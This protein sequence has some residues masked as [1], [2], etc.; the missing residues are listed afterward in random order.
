VLWTSRCGASSALDFGVVAHFHF[1]YIILIYRRKLL[2]YKSRRKFFFYFKY[3]FSSFYLT[4]LIYYLV[5]I[6]QKTL[7]CAVHCIR[8]TERALNKIY[9]RNKKN[10][11]FFFVKWNFCSY[12]YLFRVPIRNQHIVILL[13][14][15]PG[16]KC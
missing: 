15:C 1:T 13:L 9:I 16:Y 8:H 5:Y 6:K 4:R 7:Q 12:Y 2:N 11:K 14:W 3:I 10:E